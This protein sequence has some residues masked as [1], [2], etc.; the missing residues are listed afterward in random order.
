MAIDERKI[1]EAVSGLGISGNDEGL[2]PAFGLYLTKHFADYYNRVSFATARRLER[3]PDL[4]EDAGYLLIEA[5]HVC[6]FNTFG[7]IMKSAEW[8]AVVRPMIESREDWIYGM[9]AVVN[10][11]GWGRWKVR[12]LLPDYRLVVSVEDSYEAA[13]WLR[14]YP[15]SDRPRCY[16]ANGGVAGLMNLLYVGDITGGPELTQEYYERQFGHSTSFTS[17]EV[18]CRAKGDPLCLFIAQ[19][20]PAA[21]ATAT[22]APPR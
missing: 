15:Q 20:V 2:I 6:A 17:S 21:T 4:V 18:L 3:T 12:E 16:L 7:G 8:D 19:K 13:G 22:D 10:T 1:I 5:G 14:D 9:T 11:F